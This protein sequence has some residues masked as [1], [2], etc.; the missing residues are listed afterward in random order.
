MV[1]AASVIIMSN[2]TRVA[3]ALNDLYRS[4]FTRED[5]EALTGLVQDYFLSTDDG[6]HKCN[7]ECMHEY[8]EY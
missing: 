7:T 4:H 1:A 6:K 2:E 3:A 5:E 8:N